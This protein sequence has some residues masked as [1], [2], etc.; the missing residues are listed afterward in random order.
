[1]HTVYGYA[2][3]V[4]LL[5]FYHVYANNIVLRYKNKKWQS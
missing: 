1:M 2:I 5:H 3:T 4:I